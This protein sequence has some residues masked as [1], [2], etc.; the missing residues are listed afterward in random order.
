[1]KSISTIE[2]KK[3]TTENSQRQSKAPRGA[4]I[5][6]Y[7]I[8]KSLATKGHTLVNAAKLHLQRK[9]RQEERQAHQEKQAAKAQWHNATTPSTTITNNAF[10]IADAWEESRCKSIQLKSEN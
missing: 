8:E 3:E 10:H 1:M 4:G 9:A 5:S 2:R 6:G 7:A